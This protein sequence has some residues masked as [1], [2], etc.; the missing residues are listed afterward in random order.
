MIEYNVR[1]NTQTNDNKIKI[2]FG[3]YEECLKYDP[4]DV[5]FSVYDPRSNEEVVISLN[6]VPYL[7]RALEKLKEI[8]KD[9]KVND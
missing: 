6:D 3:E 2:N 1:K 5:L 8:S 4:S 9:D 7:I